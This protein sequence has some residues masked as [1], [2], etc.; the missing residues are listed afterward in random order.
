MTTTCPQCHSRELSQSSQFDGTVIDADECQHDF[1][2][3]HCGCLF[4]IIYAPI[5]TKI[6]QRGDLLLP[7]PP[8]AHARKRR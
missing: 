3:G 1:E 8:I 4:N 5:Q 6:F 2:C 7:E